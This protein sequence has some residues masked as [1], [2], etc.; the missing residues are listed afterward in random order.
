MKVT[1][2]TGAQQLSSHFL[3]ARVRPAILLQV[4]AFP[5]SQTSIPRQDDVSPAPQCLETRGRQNQS[6]LAWGVALSPL[7]LCCRTWWLKAYALCLGRAM[8]PMTG[9]GQGRIGKRDESRGP[10]CGM[11]WAESALT[12]ALCPSHSSVHTG[13]EHRLNPVLWAPGM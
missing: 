12:V 7:L 6:Q 5:Q 10:N 8:H 3:M 13:L 2:I 4:V 1:D 11:P 9:S